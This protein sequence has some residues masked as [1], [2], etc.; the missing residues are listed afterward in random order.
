MGTLRT[1]GLAVA[2]M[3][4]A[5]LLCVPAFAEAKDG[6]MTQKFLDA[7]QDHVR[8]DSKNA[9]FCTHYS[10]IGV[11]KGDRLGIENLHLFYNRVPRLLSAS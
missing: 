1:T 5:A 10:W 8:F 3:A 4:I 9:A 2:A 6:S 11:S 7:L